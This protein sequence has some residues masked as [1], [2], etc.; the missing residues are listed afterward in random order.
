MQLLSLDGYLATVVLILADTVCCA[1]TSF[2]RAQ[3]FL[4][5]QRGVGCP[6][7]AKRFQNF[8]LD[9]HLGRVELGDSRNPCKETFVG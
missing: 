9:G 6:V 4:G 8:K 7:S 5:W 3:N 2:E 1:S